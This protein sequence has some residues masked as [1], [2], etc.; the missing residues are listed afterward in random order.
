MEV[1]PRPDCV[2]LALDAAAELGRLLLAAVEVAA[3]VLG[4]GDQAEPGVGRVHG[5]DRRGAGTLNF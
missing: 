5:G 4:E 1:L 3:G 2:E